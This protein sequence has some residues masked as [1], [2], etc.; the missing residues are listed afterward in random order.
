MQTVQQTPEVSR[1]PKGAAPPN[2]RHDASAVAANSAITS[3]G[4]AVVQ[5]D[6]RLDPADEWNRTFYDK[7]EQDYNKLCADDGWDNIRQRQEDFDLRACKQDAIP[8]DSDY[9]R[10]QLPSGAA[11]RELRCDVDAGAAARS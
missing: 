10:V 11:D 2:S 3:V 5:A 6:A 4:E 7:M 1:A 9:F 8:A